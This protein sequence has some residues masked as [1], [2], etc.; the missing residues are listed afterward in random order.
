MGKNMTGNQEDPQGNL[1]WNPISS[2]PSNRT[3]T[4]SNIELTRCIQ[5]N[6]YT[7]INTQIN[8]DLLSDT[9]NRHNSLLE[10]IP[11]KLFDECHSM[12]TKNTNKFQSQLYDSL[13]DDILDLNIPQALQDIQTYEKII[14]KQKICKKQ[15]LEL[16]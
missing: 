6:C 1:Q 4:P 7:L 8:R 11:P 5:S 9:M 14:K 2:S 13:T 16:C 15:C 12:L 3:A 10:P